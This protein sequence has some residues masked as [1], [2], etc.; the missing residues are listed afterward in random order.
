MDPHPEEASER[1]LFYFYMVKCIGMKITFENVVNVAEGLALI[2]VMW[3][4]GTMI[5]HN[6]PAYPDINQQIADHNK[7]IE[8][9]DMCVKNYHQLSVG[10]ISA[11]C[12]KY[13]T[14]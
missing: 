14:K 1:L 4:V 9:R 7:M 6:A 3:F 11:N 8:E 2:A 10:E 12:L 5:V 13:F